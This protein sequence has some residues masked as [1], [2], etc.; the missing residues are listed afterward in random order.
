MR[1]CALVTA[2]S[3]VICAP[4]VVSGQEAKLVQTGEKLYADQKCAMCHSI[5]GKGNQKGPLDDVG[6]RLSEEEI[7]Q[8][9]INPRV[10]TTKTNSTRKPLMPAY[11]KLTA[12]QLNALIAYMQSLKKK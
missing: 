6:S 1:V 11:T 2:I 9:L 7:R 4:A 3:F 10:M 5:A 12:E 8:W